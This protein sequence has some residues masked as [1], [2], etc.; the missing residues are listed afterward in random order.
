MKIYVICLKLDYAHSH[1]RI[2]LLFENEICKYMMEIYIAALQLYYY[3]KLPKYPY[4][5]YI[6]RSMG[7]GQCTVLQT[8]QNSTNFTNTL[9]QINIHVLF[10]MI[11][12]KKNSNN[13]YLDICIASISLFFKYC[14][15][16]HAQ[17]HRAYNS[18]SIVSTSHVVDMYIS[19]ESIILR[20]KNPQFY[21]ICL[22]VYSP[23]YIIYT[24]I[25]HVLDKYET[26]KTHDLSLPFQIQNHNDN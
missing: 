19:V 2:S 12:Y 13:Y 25:G 20:Y 14:S 1:Q 7:W 9:Q 5:K 24:N 4:K 8:L 17:W 10:I 16:I 23:Q 21:D 11:Y 6:V 26:Q 18:Y 3:I 15:A 22:L